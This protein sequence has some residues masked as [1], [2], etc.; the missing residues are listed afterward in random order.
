MSS[1]SYN[2][3]LVKSI[4]LEL[5]SRSAEYSNDP[6]LKAQPFYRFLRD[7]YVWHTNAIVQ[8][9]YIFL[10]A[11]VTWLGELKIVY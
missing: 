6:E 2:T 1:Q 10:D 9:Y 5:G 11:C 7:T 4:S 8:P 3:E